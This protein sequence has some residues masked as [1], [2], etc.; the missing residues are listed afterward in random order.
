MTTPRPRGIEST[1][2]DLPSGTT[3][4][5]GPKSDIVDPQ[6][7][8]IKSNNADAGARAQN[9]ASLGWK[10]YRASTELA[11]KPGEEEEDAAEMEYYSYRDIQWGQGP[12][13]MHRFLTGRE[14]WGIR[15]VYGLT[16]YVYL[17][18][19]SSFYFVCFCD[20]V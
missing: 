6:E 3:E 15:P 8:R 16:A 13:R 7:S 17:T 11:L 4:E 14:D 1:L 2:P 9:A 12:V 10:K 18:M 20:R 19:L 5:G